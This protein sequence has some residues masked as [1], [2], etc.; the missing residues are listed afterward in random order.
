M[1]QTIDD[2]IT[3]TRGRPRAE[4]EPT[5]LRQILSAIENKQI[6]VTAAAKSLG[7]STTTMYRRIAEFY[8]AF[9]ALKQA[10]AP[11]VRIAQTEPK[12]RKHRACSQ[13]TRNIEQEL[14]RSNLTLSE[15]SRKYGISRERVRQIRERMKER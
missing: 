2:N 6:S 15:L 7:I 1:C 5:K 3:E 14:R 11:V 13:Q 4:V 9:P 8:D 12:T 10:P